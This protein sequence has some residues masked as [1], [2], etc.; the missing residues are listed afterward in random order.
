MTEG[1]GQPR[2]RYAAED[3]PCIED[4][5]DIIGI[6]T[7]SCGNVTGELDDVEEWRE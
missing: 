5:K 7:F 3:A 6:E 2:G 1:I 4:R